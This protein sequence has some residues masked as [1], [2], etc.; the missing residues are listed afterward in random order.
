[1]SNNIHQQVSAR[2][3]SG[4]IATPQTDEQIYSNASTDGLSPL[5]KIMFGVMVFLAV[6]VRFLPHNVQSYIDALYK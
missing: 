1:V 2:S 3:G 5:L 6:I 4:R